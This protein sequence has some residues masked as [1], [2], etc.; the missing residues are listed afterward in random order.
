MTDRK[1]LVLADVR[2]AVVYQI[3]SAL[4]KRTTPVIL[5]QPLN[6]GLT[7]VQGRLEATVK[8]VAVVHAP[9]R[10]HQSPLIIVLG[11]QHI[12]LGYVLLRAALP[13]AIHGT[14]QIIPV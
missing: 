5:Q 10:R 6:R 2:T 12:A 7:P 9:H 8:Y 1:A 13:S 3:A 14:L 11:T 4:A